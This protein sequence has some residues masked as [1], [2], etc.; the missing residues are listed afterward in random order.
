[1]QFADIIELI[2]AYLE[3]LIEA[4]RL[5]A[6]LDLPAPQVKAANVVPSRVARLK[7]KVVSKL[8]DPAQEVAR[9]KPQHRK[10]LTSA[11]QKLKSDSQLVVPAK[12]HGTSL[13]TVSAFHGA[14]V[15]QRE[16][17]IRA[18]EKG[19]LSVTMPIVRARV[20][21][22]SLKKSVPL[23]PPVK[24]GA[25]ALG[26]KIPTGPIV[27]S[28]QQIRKELSLRQQ[29]ATAGRDPFLSPK[30]IPLTAELLA[31]RWIQGS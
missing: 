12:I 16:P 15:K 1:M 13:D 19:T 24:M 4:R 29:E 18:I 23:Q 7:S 2:D 11:V 27:V 20:S 10:T 17:E 3:R 25:L 30:S 21:Q 22:P 5:L 14:T 6:E 26:G 31:Q 9:P 8:P 28:A